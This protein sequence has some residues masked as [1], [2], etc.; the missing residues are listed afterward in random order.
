MHLLIHVNTA[1]TVCRQV[2]ARF[3]QTTP[4]AFKPSN[5][6]IKFWILTMPIIISVLCLS[7]FRSLYAN[8]KLFLKKKENRMYGRIQIENYS[9]FSF[10]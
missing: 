6:V 1:C 9:I 4:P 7:L 10:V 3:A 2:C 5:R 8:H